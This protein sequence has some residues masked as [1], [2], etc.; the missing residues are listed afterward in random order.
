MRTHM[1]Y[2]TSQHNTARHC[3]ARH[4]TTGTHLTQ[5]NEYA[6]HRHEHQ[7][8]QRSHAAHVAQ[9]EGT[10]GALWH[11]CRLAFQVLHTI[12]RNHLRRHYESAPNQCSTTQERRHTLAS[13]CSV[14]SVEWLESI[15]T[16]GL[17]RT[18][19]GNFCATSSRT[20]RKLKIL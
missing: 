7:L 14:K 1:S 2:S 11:L 6:P 13:L 9:H 19:S 4:G 3:T 10:Y 8:K 20:Q 12:I 18:T 5:C 16:V 17:C 15:M